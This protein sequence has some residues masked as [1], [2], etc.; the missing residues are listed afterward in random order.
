MITAFHLMTHYANDYYDRDAD[1]RG[2][3]TAFSG[4]SGVL[5]SGALVPAT[6]L[7]AA[8]A[9]AA[10]G[11]AAVVAFAFSGASLAAGSGAANG[12]G[13]WAYSAPPFR[14]AAR[15]W[16]EIDAVLVVG[17]LV[18]LAGFAT[19]AGRVDAGAMAA[20]AGPACAMFGMMI[21]VEWP[22]CAADAAGG[23]R[24]LVVRLGR[25]RAATLAAVAAAAVIP[26]YGVAIAAGAPFALAAFAL[27]LV[28]V[29]A[30]FAARCRAAD[31][32]PIEVAARGVTL[33]ALTVVFE[34]G[35]YLAS[36]R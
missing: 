11:T 5:V 8:L 22:D 14:L 20:T 23:K 13:A 29:I 35:A 24:N 27:L 3:P 26:A 2:R 18:P 30:G 10:V 36:L 25:A 6:A 21:A 28:P 1:E 4:G 7:A 15:G 9:C 16:G 34:L 31:G 12:A 19:I 32:P 17:V 33:F